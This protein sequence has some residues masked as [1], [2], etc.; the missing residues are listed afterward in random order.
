MNQ[1]MDRL[2]ELWV[3]FESFGG[4]ANQTNRRQDDEYTC[5][6]G[7]V[8]I[9][10][11]DF[12]TC[13]ECGRVDELFI[14]N[15]P[16]WIAGE[17]GP[18]PS[19]VGG[20]SD[21]VLFSEKWGMGTLISGRSCQKMAKINFHS[22][23]NHRDRALYHA[24]SDLDLICKV[25]LGLPDTIVDCVKV[26]YKKMSE[27]KLTRGAIR[28]GIK[29][30]CVLYACKEHG[31]QRTFQEIANAFGIP[32]KDISRT[33]ELFRDTIGD[34]T[35]KTQSGDII[36]RIFNQIQFI[37]DTST[38][39]RIVIKIIRECEVAQNI[40]DLMGKTPKGVA[41]AII[42]ETLQAMGYEEHADKAFVARICDVSVPTL[43]KILQLKKRAKE[44]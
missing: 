1:R 41:S 24:Y 27:D 40:P 7:G 38:K 8:K 42:Y 6:C 4:G 30:N 9:F 37:S 22:N 17:D 32:V 33:S 20:P 5:V 12:P 14:S 31:V 16:E 15:E 26:T 28:L 18:D 10:T 25:K 3:Q 36:Q 39:R 43:T 23:M 11:N 35:G 44:E 34:D 2:D 19:R 21:T 13:I 29:A